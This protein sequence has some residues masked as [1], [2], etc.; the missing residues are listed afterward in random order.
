MKLISYLRAKY[1]NYHYISIQEAMFESQLK[2]TELADI[3]TS[4]GTD[5]YKL[6]SLI[7]ENNQDV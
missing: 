3:T 5:M 6:A 7:E 4:H 1:G 2:A